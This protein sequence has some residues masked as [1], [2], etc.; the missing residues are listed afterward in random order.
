MKLVRSMVVS[1]FFAFTTSVAAK[2][3]DVREI[4]TN[5]REMK[6]I[7]LAMGRSTVL[8][9]TEKPVKVV[10]GNSNYF[11]VEFVGN[12]L[13]LQPLANVETNLF[14]YLQSKSKFGFHLKVGSVSK[15]DDMVY[16]RFKSDSPALIS[17]DSRLKPKKTLNPFVID[18][19][20]MELRVNQLFPLG[21][22]KAYVLD[23]VVKNKSSKMLMPKDVKIFISQKDKLVKG[24][25]IVF[26]K[27]G[28]EKQQDVRGRIFF[29]VNKIEGLQL[30]ASFKGIKRRKDLSKRYH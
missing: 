8:S 20:K 25:R 17:G 23:F 1:V 14:V 18:L 26:E 28:F 9:F 6:T 13:T 16:V 15:C 22:T 3:S 5:D 7:H 24:Q 4:F 27:D 2:K 12:D 19:G 21:E 30:D 29:S 10:A 11:N